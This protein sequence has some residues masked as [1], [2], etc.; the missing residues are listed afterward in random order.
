M[1]VCTCSDLSWHAHVHVCG[2]LLNPAD[3]EVFSDLPQCVTDIRS[4][5]ILQQVASALICAG[6]PDPSFKD[7]IESEGGSF[8]GENKE[9]VATLDDTYNATVSGCRYERQSE[10]RSVTSYVGLTALVKSE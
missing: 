4:L 9:I 10:C 1:T 3:S 8:R 5:F 6:N 7:L 2:Q